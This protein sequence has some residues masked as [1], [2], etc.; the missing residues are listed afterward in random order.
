MLLKQGDTD[1]LRTFDPERACV[2]ANIR[3]CSCK[4]NREVGKSRSYHL[5]RAAR[6]DARCRRVNCH[7]LVAPQR[8]PPAPAPFSGHHRHIHR[9]HRH[10]IHHL[11]LRNRA[12]HR[13]PFPTVR[14]QTGVSTPPRGVRCTPV[15]ASFL[16]SILQW[17]TEESVES[18]CGTVKA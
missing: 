11:H 3:N 5:D 15:S 2:K 8:L 18:Y 13:P 10:H 1:D 12:G 14:M 6:K 9:R 4:R 7:P 17:A 16:R